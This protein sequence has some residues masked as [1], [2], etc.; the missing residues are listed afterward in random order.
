MSYDVGTSMASPSAAGAAA[1]IRQYFMDA[2]F[3][4]TTAEITAAEGMDAPKELANQAL[5]NAFAPSGMLVKAVILHAGT[6][7]SRYH[8]EGHNDIILGNPPDQYQGY[9]RINLGDV[10]PLKGYNKVNLFVRDLERIYENGKMKYE[11]YVQDTSIPF[12]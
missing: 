11:A 10:L 6:K 4:A 5:A 8:K 2:N 7:M 12:K 1:L 3:Y 9:G